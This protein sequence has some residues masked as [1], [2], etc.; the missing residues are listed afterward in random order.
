MSIDIALNVQGIYKHYSNRL[1]L[2]NVSLSVNSGEVFGLIGLNG[3]GKTTLIKIMMDLL[4]SDKGS[5]SFF[6]ISSNTHKSRENVFYLPEKFSPS[7]FLKGWE[8]LSM[9]LNYYNKK[10]SDVDAKDLCNRFGLSNDFLYKRISSYSK[11]MGQKL[12]LISVF[13]S[14]A[15]LLMLDEPMSGLDP[16][17]RIMVKREIKKHCSNGGTVFFSSHI[18]SDIDEVCNRMSVLH[19]NSVMFTGTPSELLSLHNTNNMETAFLREIGE[20]V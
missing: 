2:D 1:V 3:I 6:G 8:F 15:K 4:G 20:S 9:V 12:G 10:Y 5:I 13:I 16:S 14:G 11:G 18:L 19:N 7:P 17:A